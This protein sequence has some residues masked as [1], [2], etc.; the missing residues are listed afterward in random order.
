MYIKINKNKSQHICVA[1]YIFGIVFLLLILQARHSHLAK[2]AV[3]FLMNWAYW[4]A[5]YKEPD[6][7]GAMG[8]AA[9]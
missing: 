2:R 9:A 3:Y 5:G 1:A 7:T 8:E 6:Q 4:A